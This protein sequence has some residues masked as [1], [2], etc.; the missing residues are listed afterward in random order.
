MKQT[1]SIQLEE[2]WQSLGIKKGT[3]VYCHSFLSSLGQIVPNPEIVID[4]LINQIGHSGT[5]VVPTFS[6]S[7]FR[8]K[9]YDVQKSDSVVGALGNMI[10][11]RPDAIRSLDPNFSMAAIGYQAGFLM[12]RDSYFSFGLGSIYDKL[13][14]CDP[15]VLLLG[16]DY[17]ALSLFMHFEKMAA[18]NYRYD[19]IFEGTSRK[20]DS[21]Y[22]DR[23]IHFVNDLDIDP[24]CDRNRIGKLIDQDSDCNKISFAYGV[25]RLI[26]ARKIALIVAKNLID[27]PYCLIK[28]NGKIRSNKDEGALF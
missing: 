27:D 16:V 14:T 15:Q 2:L 25:H 3:V 5:L 20:G 24:V 10:R 21:L 4:T 7:H 17:T 23:S 18:V 8:G 19:K 28:V 9:I 11:K 26:P 22:K 6:W 1:S 13:M 12:Q